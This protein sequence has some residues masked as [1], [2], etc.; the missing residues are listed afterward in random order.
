MM[1]WPDIRGFPS[2]PTVGGGHSHITHN[3]R[4][5]SPK[6]CKSCCPARLRSTVHFVILN[7]FLSSDH[8]NSDLFCSLKSLNTTIRAP[9]ESSPFYAR[10]LPLLLLRFQPKYPPLDV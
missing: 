10:C 7:C 2:R 3:G 9:F 5:A 6:K 8:H 1:E 4:A